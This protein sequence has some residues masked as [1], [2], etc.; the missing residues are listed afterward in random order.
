MK[1]KIFV[2]IVSVLLVS[3]SL[4]SNVNALPTH[5]SQNT[6][7]PTL[8]PMLEKVTP[9]VVNISTKGHYYGE[10]QLPD[11]FNDP[12]FKRF[13]NFEIPEQKKARPRA[14]GSGVVVNAQ[15]GYV[16]TN[17]HVIDN[18]SEIL[19]TLRDGRKIKAELIGTDPQTDIALLKVNAKKL[20]EVELGDSDKLRV[21]DFALAIG[22]PF[23]LDQT[24]TSGIISGLGRSGLGIEG[25]EDF[26]QTD[27]SINPGNSGGAL[28]NLRGELIGINT[29]IFSRSGGNIGI[30]FAIPVNMAKSVMDQLIQYGSIQR[31]LLGVQIQDLT[32]ELAK[33]FG[34]NTNRG[35]VVAQ[36]VDDS[37]A[38]KAG[39]KAGDIIIGVN[40]RKIESSTSLRNYIGLKR[41]GDKAELKVIRG[42]DKL[43]IKAII[44]GEKKT[45]TQASSDKS[46]GKNLQ[47]ESLHSSLKGA[48]FAES[49]GA[50][51]VIN[52]KQG[53]PAWRAGLREDDKLIAI[54]RH[55]IQNLSSLKKFSK[56]TQGTTIALNIHRGNTA[57]FL[58]LQ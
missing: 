49:N 51:K 27:A 34:V 6:P 46:S 39:I 55:R 38:D 14:L 44:G 58:V 35:A 10:S 24:V 37:A 32:P 33:A 7:L 45:A 54:N 13:F 41:P 43:T 11:I 17:N 8:A 19:V 53:S 20:H 48:T 29:A 50:V 36:V 12:F 4:F 40:G 31:G 16:L 56:I 57:L 23:G 42:K 9:A 25:Y 47:G 22:H 18:A 52:I 2:P 28:V 1:T 3:I 15:K 21:G 30:G 5:D 26:I